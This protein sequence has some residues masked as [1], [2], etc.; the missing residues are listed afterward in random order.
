MCQGLVC[1]FL[2]KCNINKQENHEKATL[3]QNISLGLNSLV[4]T[5]NVILSTLEINV[6]DDM[7]DATHSH[8]STAAFI[9]ANL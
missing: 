3:G 2:G 7:E 5:L 8:N 6:M 1:V 9:E 4:V